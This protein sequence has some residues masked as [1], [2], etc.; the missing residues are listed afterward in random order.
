VRTNELHSTLVANGLDVP[1]S[2]AAE[3]DSLLDL[4]MSMLVAPS[5]ARDAIT[6][7]HDFPA[8]QAALAQVRGAVASRFEAFWGELELCNGFHE[9]GNAAEQARRFEMD[10]AERRRRGQPDREP[11]Q[12]FISSLA[13]GLPPCAGVALGF[14]RVVMI[15]AGAASIDEV[16]AFPAERA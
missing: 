14:D 3:H 2:V 4:G 10:R 12:L 9:L 13:A 1:A 7:V 6:F 16:V 5:F 11:D 15:A 8:S